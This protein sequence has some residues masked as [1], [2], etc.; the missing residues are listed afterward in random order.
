MKI[1]CENCRKQLHV[2]GWYDDP[3]RTNYKEKENVPKPKSWLRK[4]WDKLMETNWNSLFSGFSGQLIKFI[5]RFVLVLLVSIVSA[6]LIY[7]A[8]KSITTDGKVDYCGIEDVSGFNEKKLM[9]YGHRRWRPD[10][11]YGNCP[12]IEE[13]IRIAKQLDCEIGIIK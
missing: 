12:S 5:W 13:C 3:Y 6:G 8:Y 4:K 10:S 2:S 1:L 9:I 11:N 7:V